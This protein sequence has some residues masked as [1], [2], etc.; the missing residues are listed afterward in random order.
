MFFDTGGLETIDLDLIRHLDSEDKQTL[1]SFLLPR[2]VFNVFL[3]FVRFIT[4]VFLYRLQILPLL[5]PRV[6]KHH[7][8]NRIRIR[9]KRNGYIYSP[10]TSRENWHSDG[11]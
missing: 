5:K 10:I 8:S 7:P 3:Y 4:F 2:R 9:K 1:S 6:A 11:N